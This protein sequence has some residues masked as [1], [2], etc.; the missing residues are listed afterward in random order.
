MGKLYTSRYANKDLQTSDAI[1]VS[2][3][4]SKPR[5][6]LKYEISRTLAQLAPNGAIFNLTDKVAFTRKYTEQ[7]E[8]IGFPTVLEMLKS[9]GYGSEKDVILLC[10]EDITCDDP[11]K[12]WCHRTILGQ[13]LEKHGIEV[14]EYPDSN[15]FANKPKKEKKPVRVPDENYLDG[16][17]ALF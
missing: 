7:L 14:K 6:P 11:N 5:F 4:R 12:N 3:S 10:Y 17:M 15:C 13:W 8:R 2:I 16:Q 9:V 1:K